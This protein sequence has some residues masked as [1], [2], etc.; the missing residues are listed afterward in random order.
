MAK[1][2]HE[3]AVV[4]TLFIPTVASASEMT[5]IVS[6]GALNSTHSLLQLQMGTK[7]K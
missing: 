2:V 4:A 1:K 7:R 3:N 5:Y 6:V